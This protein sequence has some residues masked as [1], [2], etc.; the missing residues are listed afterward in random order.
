MVPEFVSNFHTTLSHPPWTD[1]L[2]WNLH[3][4]LHGEERVPFHA[5][6]QHRQP[7]AS[8]IFFPLFSILPAELHLR[9]LSFCSPQV[10]F[11]V[12]RVSSALRVEASKL[13]WAHR[14]AYVQVPTSWLL[15]GA[16]PN[17]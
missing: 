9:I 4:T 11:Q 5:Y 7:V 3:M 12:M 6:V 17:Y 2:R 1:T 10:L 15:S 13:F 8:G 14:E 16:Y